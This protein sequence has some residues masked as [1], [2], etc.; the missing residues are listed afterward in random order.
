MGARGEG[1][2]QPV[3]CYNPTNETGALDLKGQRETWRSAVNLLFLLPS[4]PRVVSGF[5][6][7]AAGVRG[8]GYAVSG[9]GRLGGE[10]LWNPLEMR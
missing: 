10:D 4:L 8:R 9:R 3:L 5:P 2:L 7:N 6:G 1:R